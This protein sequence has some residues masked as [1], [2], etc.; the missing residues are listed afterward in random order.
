MYNI[1]SYRSNSVSGGVFTPF[2]AK[3]PY[4]GLSTFKLR[5]TLEVKEKRESQSGLVI[6]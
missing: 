4:P 5:L 1:Y 2:E 3:F 6:G